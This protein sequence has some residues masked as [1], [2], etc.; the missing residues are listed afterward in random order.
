MLPTEL[1]FCFIDLQIDE[2]I[3]TALREEGYTN[4]ES[5]RAAYFTGS[6]D[7]SVAREWL[8]KENIDCK[9]S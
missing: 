3:V 9:F 5:L 2:L 8:E 1:R 6:T 4:E 7:V